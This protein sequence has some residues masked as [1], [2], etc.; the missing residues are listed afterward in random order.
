MNYT[1]LIKEVVYDCCSLK[2]TN[3]LLN[4]ESKEYFACSYLLNEKKIISRTA[5]ITPKK[6]GQFVVL[7]KRIDNGPIK[8][9][10]CF[11][12]IDSVVVNVKDEN[13]FG[14]F[15]FPKAELVNQGVFS[16]DLKEGKRAIR[17]YP[18]WVKVKSK[19][20]IKTQLWQL[21]YFLHLPNDELVDLNRARILYS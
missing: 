16:T 10:H 17:V 1:E 7:W 11:D 19:Q 18:P 2:L 12:A 21:K 20:A 15:I 9:Y 13:Y 8:P 6:N 5:K 3:Y 14:Q 4:K